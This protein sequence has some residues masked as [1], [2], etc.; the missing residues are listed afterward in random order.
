MALKALVTPPS[1]FITNQSCEVK[2]LQFFRILPIS[3]FAA[4]STL[5]GLSEPSY[6]VFHSHLNFHWVTGILTTK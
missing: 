1:I 5:L 2:I 4:P 6:S 3:S